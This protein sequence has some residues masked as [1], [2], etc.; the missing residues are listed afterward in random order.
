LNITKAR[1]YG[2]DKDVTKTGEDRRIVLCPRAVAIIERQLRLREREVF[3]GL[4]RHDHLFFTASGA[5]MM[6]LKYAYWRRQRTLR[7]LAI[8]YRKPYMA[9]HTSV[10]WNLMLGGNPLRVA[11]EHGHR[12]STM[13]AV[14]AAWI[15]GAADADI[16]AI[17]DA[18]NRTGGEV[19][20]ATTPT[21]VLPT[22]ISAFTECPVTAMPTAA[23]PCGIDGPSPRVF[24]T[25]Y[26]NRRQ[27]LNYNLILMEREGLEP[28]TPAL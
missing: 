11:K 12:I 5:P 2:I 7:R 26:A 23:S 8:R 1:V 19:R 13:F 20:E 21:V 16:G 3:A 18:M 24:A 10:S 4:I 22:Q 14:Y 9:R 27:P 6:D 17:R 28:S 25:S 15:E